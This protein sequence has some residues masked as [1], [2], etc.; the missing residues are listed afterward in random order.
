LCLKTGFWF[1]A[2]VRLGKPAARSRRMWKLNSI[3]GHGA[4]ARDRIG[5][6]SCCRGHCGGGWTLLS[7]VGGGCIARNGGKLVGGLVEQGVAAAS[8]V[9]F[10]NQPTKEAVLIRRAGRRSLHTWPAHSAER[11]ALV[12]MGE[13]R[14][15]VDGAI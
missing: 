11:A 7:G 8:H 6:R 15:D 12:S 5:R 2:H 10:C 13:G 1:G 3:G 14:V 9:A 4:L